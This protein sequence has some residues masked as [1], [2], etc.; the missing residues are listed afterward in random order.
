MDSGGAL[1][2]LHHDD[3]RACPSTQRKRFGNSFLTHP[4]PKRCQSLP[5]KNGGHVCHLQQSLQTGVLV[6]VEI[7]VVRK[8]GSAV[9]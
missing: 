2:P 9:L 6:K 4:Q 5:R 3:G 7:E 1:A 8:F